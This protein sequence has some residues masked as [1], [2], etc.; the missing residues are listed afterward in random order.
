MQKVLQTIKNY[1]A[2]EAVDPE[3][4]EGVFLTGGMLQ[5]SA[6][7]GTKLKSVLKKQLEKE[8][9][10]VSTSAYVVCSETPQAGSILNG[11]NILFSMPQFDQH[12]CVSKKEWHLCRECTD[13]YC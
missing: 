1:C 6:V 13:E 11:A 2:D 3:S 4:I 12:L 7:D 8:L 10:Q 9:V 5:L